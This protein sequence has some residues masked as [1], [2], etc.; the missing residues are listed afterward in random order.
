MYVASH[1][2][3]LLEEQL[4]RKKISEI[5]QSYQQD[6]LGM[7]VPALAFTSRGCE[8]RQRGV[9]SQALETFRLEK[10]KEVKK[11]HSNHG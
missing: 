6:H 10:D 9:Q 1:L 11:Q 3:Y 5:S 7:E 8:G 4:L 2:Q